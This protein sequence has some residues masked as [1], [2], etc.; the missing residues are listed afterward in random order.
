[1]TRNFF[2]TLKISL[3]CPKKVSYRCSGL[4]W[5]FVWVLLI[6][7][8]KFKNQERVANVTRIH[9]MF[10]CHQTRIFHSFM[11]QGNHHT[12]K[13]KIYITSCISVIS[14]LEISVLHSFCLLCQHTAQIH[15]LY[16]DWGIWHADIELNPNSKGKH[17]RYLF[18]KP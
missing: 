12:T 5:L 14:C 4:T 8:A 13:Q 15:T 2:S 16:L 10:L 9:C 1:M 6:F 7:Y 11:S 3:F 17:G 18:L